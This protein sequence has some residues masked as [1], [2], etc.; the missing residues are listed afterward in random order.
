MAKDVTT[1]VLKA[2]IESA[3]TRLK[4]LETNINTDLAN[5][6]LPVGLKAAIQNMQGIQEAYYLMFEQLIKEREG[7][8]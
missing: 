7:S 6:N 2:Y 3:N 1:N 5:V 4:S 8:K